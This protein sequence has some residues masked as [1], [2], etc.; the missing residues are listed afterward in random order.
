MHIFCAVYEQIRIS[1]SLTFPNVV[2]VYEIIETPAAVYIITEYCEDGDLFDYVVRK[3]RLQEDEARRIFHQVNIYRPYIGP[4][5]M[6]D[7][8]TARMQSSGSF[9]TTLS[10]FRI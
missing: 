2:R 3:G 7:E 10:I 4:E 8:L 9:Q 5:F 6:V 1:R